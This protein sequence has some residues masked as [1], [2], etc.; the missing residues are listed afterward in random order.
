MIKPITRA[1][2][3]KLLHMVKDALTLAS[4]H[5]PEHEQRLYILE[6]QVERLGAPQYRV[7][8]AGRFSPLKRKR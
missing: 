3:N 7:V 6:R 5:D 2:Y 8:E 4:T 1:E